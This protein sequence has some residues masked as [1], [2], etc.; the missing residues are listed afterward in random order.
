MRSTPIQKQP[1]LP[2][3]LPH[4]P[5]PA[6]IPVGFR[7][8]LHRSVRVWAGGSVVAGGAP[9]RLSRLS[10][11]VVSLVRA[12]SDPGVRQDGLSVE[13]PHDRAMARS[14]LD[15][16]LVEP[17]SP[18]VASDQVGERGVVDVVVPAMDQPENVRALL[19]SVSGHR[20]I[21]VD[22]G[23]E[24]PAPLRAVV[25]GAGADLVVHEVN[26]GPS[27]A[28]N[29]GLASSTS[30]Y[31]ALIDSDC[32]ATATWIDQLL[33]HFDDPAVAVAAPRIVPLP[34]SDTVID[35]FEETRS[36]LD[37]GIRSELIRP[38]S[39]LG[40]V[41]SAA[42]VIRRSALGSSGFDEDLRLGEDVD[43]VWRLSDAGWLI[44]YDPTAV[45]YHRTR[46]AWRSWIRRRFDYGT[47]AADLEAR[48]PGRLVPARVS[49]WNLV[50]LGLL[51]TG[52]PRWAGAV[53]GAAGAL[54]WW[55]VRKLPQ[56]SLIAARVVGQG[57]L[58]DAAAVGH[59]LRREWWPVGAVTLI[60]ASRS[61]A[62]R[63]VAATML[64][65]VALE[66]L[67][68]RPRLDPITYASLR[69]L[70]DATYGSGVL[71]SSL[72]GRTVRPLVPRV[73]LPRVPFRKG[74]SHSR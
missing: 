67:S 22:D 51:A 74:A 23:S 24:H 60:A 47:S 30:P 40:F 57:V 32:I 20:I 9:W 8:R 2:P 18:M 14:L 48:H 27:F 64:V 41:P 70:A 4:R 13:S 45:V 29:T 1:A 37:M 28:R 68:R 52:R 6:P 72:R 26:R 36:A 42:M 62:A 55:E 38:G 21:V 58:A 69:L 12:L 39:R 59:L 73:R 35:R 71:V 49:S 66:W 5:V 7:I 61:R 11:P 31:V 43:L 15:R 19:Q 3:P 50:V 54:L 53:A 56:P 17:A 16:G 10:P 44:R 33:P 25:H 65:P 63:V 46:A 34:G